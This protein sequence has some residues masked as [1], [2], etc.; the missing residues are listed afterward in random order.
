MIVMDLTDREIEL[1]MIALGT[2]IGTLEQHPDA[3]NP[4]LAELFTELFELETDLR[5][6][7]N[8]QDDGRN[9]AVDAEINETPD[10]ET[11]MFN[12]GV[13]AREQ[14]KERNRLMFALES[15]GGRGVEL[16][17]QIDQLDAE[18]KAT[19][20]AAERRASKPK[21]RSE[22]QGVD[23]WDPSDPRNW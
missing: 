2:H 23:V 16:A 11:Q 9:V 7:V 6:A 12:A 17:E 21:D 14:M 4:Q 18:M 5:E 19:S 15:Q 13:E 20:R 10:A 8:R 3:S 1:L 22:I